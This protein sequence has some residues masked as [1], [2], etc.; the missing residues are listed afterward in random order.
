MF[1]SVQLSLSN[2]SFQQARKTDSPRLDWSNH[3]STQEL[4]SLFFAKAK[5]DKLPFKKNKE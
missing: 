1:I 2:W 5:A 3:W 4:V